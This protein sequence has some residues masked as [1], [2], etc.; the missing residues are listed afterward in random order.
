MKRKS[1]LT[2]QNVLPLH[3]HFSVVQDSLEHLD[4]RDHQAHPACP[5]P[6]DLQEDLAP[7]VSQDSQAPQ[8]DPAHRAS[9]DL[10][11]HLVLLEDPEP[12]ASQDSLVQ[13]VCLVSSA[14]RPTQQMRLTGISCH[15]DGSF[16]GFHTEH[17]QQSKTH[18][19]SGFSMGKQWVRWWLDFKDVALS[20]QVV[21]CLKLFFYFRIE[22]IS[23]VAWDTRTSWPCRVPGTSGFHWASWSTGRRVGWPAGSPGTTRA[24]RPSRDRRSHR[25]Q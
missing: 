15:E 24:S 25:D 10:P 3:V 23:R 22:R 12:M 20:G 19:F 16:T 8:V 7:L 2:E 11:D 13:L 21:Y 14:L 17:S 5:D 9:L 1:S 18:Y 6:Q 4:N